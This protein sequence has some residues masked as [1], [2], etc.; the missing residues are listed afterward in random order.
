MI[1]RG[2]DSADICKKLLAWENTLNDEKEV[3][4]KLIGKGALTKA[5]HARIFLK[6]L[7]MYFEQFRR[8]V[9]NVHAVRSR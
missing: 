1:N 6:R 2:Q 3:H 5:I 4:V 8:D 9:I 7:G